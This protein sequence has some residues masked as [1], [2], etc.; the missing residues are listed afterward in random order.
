MLRLGPLKDAL[1][2]ELQRRGRIMTLGLWNLV[3]CNSTDVG[4]NHTEV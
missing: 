4:S 1:T 2:A 3:C